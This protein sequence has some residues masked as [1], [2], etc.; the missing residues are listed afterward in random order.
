MAPAVGVMNY[1]LFKAS[2]LPTYQSWYHDPLLQA[3]LDPPPDEDWLA[4]VLIQKDGFLVQR[5]DQ[6]NVMVAVVGITE[7]RE[8]DG[9]SVLEEIAVN[10]NTRRG[11]IGRSIVSDLISDKR[12]GPEWHALV[13]KDNEQ[14]I[15][16]L[17]GLGWHR[18]SEH[19][20]DM[21]WYAYSRT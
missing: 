1:T 5:V 17:T 13:D 2:D 18:L 14:M 4:E 16:L 10:P 15:G 8:G 12:W 19:D 6:D 3:H 9:V 11:G 7:R 21:D 20:E